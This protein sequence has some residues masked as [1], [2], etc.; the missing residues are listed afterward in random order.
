LYSKKKIL[1]PGG[2]G[3]LGYHTCLFFK[4]KGWIVHSI[5]KSKPKRIRYIKNVK[6]ILCDVADKSKLIN[7]L[8]NYYDYIVNLSGYVDHSKNKSILKT[9]FD[10]CKNLISIFKKKNLKKFIQIGSSI[11]YGNQPSPQNEDKINKKASTYS[12]YGDA[13]L[14]TSMYLKNLFLKEKVP[15]TI[16]RLYLVYGPYQDNNRV[17]PF[18]INNCIK[19]N[20]FN[21]SPG[22]QYRD[23]IFVDDVVKAIYQSLKSKNSNGEIINIGNGTPIKIKNL[24]NKIRNLIGHGNPNFSQINYRKDE[25]LKLYP[26]ILKAKKILNWSPKIDLKKGLNKTIKFYKKNE[27]T[28]NHTK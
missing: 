18:V 27:K 10:G 2:T 22:N 28:I 15:I 4:K 9:H 3:F 25:I 1:I 17:I 19:K 26:K 14:K 11:E 16:L 13:K 5:S 12:V 24:I 21:C 20:F 23:F 6:Y 7:K 8:D